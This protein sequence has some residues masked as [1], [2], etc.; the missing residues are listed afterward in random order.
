MLI[1]SHVHIDGPEFAADL[2]EVLARARA[3]GVGLLLNIGTGDPHSG[4]LQRAVQLASA[5]E[6]IYA[7]VGV[8][9]HDA[10]LYDEAAETLLLRLVRENPKVVAWG[11]IGLDYYYE[12]TPRAVQRTVF[13]RQMQCA[14]EAG[15]PVI[16]HTREADADTLAVLREYA[17]DTFA[18]GIMHCF[19]GG[20]ELLEGALSMGFYISFAGNVTFKKAENLREAARRV[21]LPRL[22]LETDCPYLTPVPYRGQRNEPARVVAVAAC[23][24]DLHGIAPEEMSRQ[25]SDNFL[26]L[27]PQIRPLAVD[28]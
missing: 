7:A 25:T 19:G 8:H 14:A 13:A 3:A 21:P 20:P 9:P 10:K 5:H 23:L 28:L 18:G 16:I 22:L 1:D 6:E 24:A 2:P 15:R 27:F 12:H 26:R 11:E 17:G 4:V